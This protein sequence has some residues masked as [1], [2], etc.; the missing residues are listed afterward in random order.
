[1][2]LQAY[3]TLARID[4]AH[5]A[6]DQA[7]RWLTEAQPLAHGRPAAEALLCTSLARNHLRGGSYPAMLQNTVQGYAAAVRAGDLK[8]Q[9]DSL[10][11]Q[12]IA[13]ARMARFS[14]ALRA[15]EQGRALYQTLAN[16]QGEASV[17]INSTILRYRTG[18]FA[19]A[20]PSLE[21]ALKLFIRLGDERGRCTA[22]L[23]RSV[24]QT[25]LRNGPAAEHDADAALAIA[26]KLDVPLL[27]ALAFS[28]LGSAL[29]VQGQLHQAINAY[30]EAFAR[31]TVNDVNVISVLV[32]C[33][34]AH[35]DL[36]HLA[37]AGHLSA[38]AAARVA[39]QPHIDL[40]QQIHAVRALVLHRHGDGDGAQA[41]LAAAQHALDAIVSSFADPRAA[42]RYRTALATNR[43]IC[44]AQHGNWDAEHPLF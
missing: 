30:A 28:S 11:L 9:A 2:R 21:A 23:N 1:L 4:Q 35:L 7:Q 38:E 33:A 13:A 12:G 16:L 27:Q 41:A 3:F 10:V 36:G 34:V 26:R 44:A 18:D 40:P 25:M 43:F 32:W 37:E 20:L 31:H 42:A 24:L 22:L 17:L 15:Y 5:E 14:E 6:Y 39:A 8:T 29:L 19:G